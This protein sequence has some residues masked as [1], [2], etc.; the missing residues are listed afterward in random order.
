MSKVLKTLGTPWRD[1]TPRSSV[2][3]SQ[4]MTT[5]YKGTPR[6]HQGK[7]S[8]SLHLVFFT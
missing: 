4:T 1:S 3:M 5:T 8:T 2:P 7:W 6:R